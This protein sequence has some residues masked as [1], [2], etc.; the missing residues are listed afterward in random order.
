MSLDGDG[1]NWSFATSISLCAMQSSFSG[2]NCTRPGSNAA[3][4]DQP[5]GEPPSGPRRLCPKGRV[6]FDPYLILEAVDSAT[7]IAKLPATPVLTFTLLLVHAERECHSCAT[8]ATHGTQAK[9]QRGREGVSRVASITN[10]VS[11]A[12]GLLALTW[13][14]SGFAQTP[15]SAAPSFNQTYEAVVAK[16]REDCK[17]LWSDHIFDP[18][19]NRIPL[20]EEKPTF[21]MLTNKEKLH[22]KDKPLADLAIKTVEK[23]RS[24]YA[25]VYNM[26]PENVNALIKGNEQRQDALIAELY[27][28]KLTL[29]DYNIEMNRLRGKFA[30][31][32][33]GI[34][35]QTQSD[36]TT[37]HAPPESAVQSKLPQP[38]TPAAP[39]SNERRLA[40]VI[41]NSN[42]AKLPRLSNPTNDARSIADALQQMGYSTQ[43]LLDASEN[44][45]R[46]AVRKFANELRNSDVGVVYYAGHGAQ[47]KGNNY[48]LPIDI[49]LPRTDADIEF[50][51]LKVDDLINSI[52]SNTKIVFLDACRDN[53][54]LFKNIA[55][56]RGG[57]PAGLAPASASSFNPAKTRWWDF[58]RLR[59]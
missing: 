55:S 24:A 7:Q 4:R 56:G 1:E 50:T 57:S 35:I 51:G 36:L 52:G 16:A 31:A 18:L 28:G 27:N 29:G 21:S 34:P 46:N 3:I 26:L 6:T 37:A 33:S 17:T 10:A 44:G 22:S 5:W 42:Y 53:P 8:Q 25:P 13:G 49:E 38:G 58:Y 30:E 45:I 9:L 54:V 41:G 19:R 14:I 59:H 20:G 32:L 11:L 23:C 12:F 40:L 43:L 48:L 39:V 15:Q 47:L 2:H